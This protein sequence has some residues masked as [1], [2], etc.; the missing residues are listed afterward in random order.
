[1]PSL[2]AGYDMHMCAWL[3]EQARSKLKRAF[4]HFGFVNPKVPNDE[5]EIE[6]RGESARSRR[7]F[8]AEFA[9]AQVFGHWRVKSRKPSVRRLPYT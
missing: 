5:S 7:P 9:S 8:L 3:I 4:N 1:M 2:R 6:R